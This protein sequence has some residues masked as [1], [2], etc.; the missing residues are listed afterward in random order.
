MVRIRTRVLSA[1]SPSHLLWHP[2]AVVAWDDAGNIVSVGPFAGEAVDEHHP[3]AVLTPGFVDAHV[4]LPQARIV[5]AASGPL[6]DWLARSTFPEE[7]RFADPAHARAVGA[8]F[9]ERLARAGTTLPFVYG[10]VHAEAFDAFLDHIADTGQR[11]MG[12]PVLMDEGAP[13]ALLRPADVALPALDALGDRWH[14]HDGRVEI[15]A[16]PRFGL[17]CSEGL[18]AG[19]ARLAAE[20]GW[21]TSTHLSEN[22]DEC[23]ATRARFGTDDYLAVYEAAGLVHERCVLAH[24]IHLSDDEWRRFADAGAVVAHCPDSNDFLGS[25]GMP[26]GPVLDGGVPWALG[27]DVAAGRSFRVPRTASAAFDNALR[28][29]RRVAP[30]HWLWVATAGGAAALG[31]P[32]LGHLRPGAPADLALHDL[33]SWIDDPHDALGHLLFAHDQG[34]TRATWV[35]GRAVWRRPPGPPAW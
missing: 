20:R 23:A 24:N 28:Q 2:D 12:G 10:S 35:R 19:A 31:H 25:G 4:H 27:T 11:V 1:S 14:G 33:P 7:A 22:P 21:W 18:M 26:L 34:P 17:S 30:V 16:I 8:W 32:E 29:G 13:P 6:L 15:A 5:G 3:D 9:A